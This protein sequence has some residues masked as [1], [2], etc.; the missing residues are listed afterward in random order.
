MKIASMTHSMSI[1]MIDALLSERLRERA[2]A[3]ALEDGTS[4]TFG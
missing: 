3:H 1:V 4:Q 2:A